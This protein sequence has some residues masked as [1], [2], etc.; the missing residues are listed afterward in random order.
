MSTNATTAE[1]RGAARRTSPYARNTAPGETMF[2]YGRGEAFYDEHGR[3]ILDFC[4]QSLNLSL[5]HCHPAVNAAIAEALEKVGYVSSRLNN[6]YMDELAHA[7]VDVAPTGLTKVNLKVASGTLANE[8]ALKI[9]YKLKAGSREVVSLLGSH[10]GQSVETMRVSGKNFMRPYLDRE[11]VSFVAPCSDA[12][13]LAGGDRCGLACAEA[14]V[15]E[16]RRRGPRLAAVILEPLLVDAGIVVPPREFLR[17]ARE[18]AWENDAVL[19]VDEV[20]T[21]FGWT[22]TMF[23]SEWQELEPDVLTVGKGFAAGMP[24]AAIL[25]REECDVLVNGEHE[26]THGGHPL[27]CAA[28]IANLELLRSTDLMASVRENGEH[29]R[30]LLREVRDDLPR[31]GAIRGKGYVVGIEI[32]E[33]GRPGL[34]KE[35]VQLCLENGVMLR[36][37]KVG[38]RS[39]VVQFKPPL[40]TP[41]ESLDEG[42]GIF[43]DVVRKLAA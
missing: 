39:N 40:V 1:V 13:W 38:E 11:G 37:S 28:A 29:L 41:R 42:V 30:D 14:L 23:A 24:L 17:A 21:A 34:T 12:C 4:A 22:G 26:I 31:L 36:T 8:G 43:A 16:A 2:A 7:V 18:A 6:S 3:R 10:H 15:E 19:I 20:Q 33:S 9:A 32:D 27:A 25:L 35:V 5:G